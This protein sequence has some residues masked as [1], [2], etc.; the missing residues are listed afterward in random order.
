M[1]GEIATG[2]NLQMG[3][4]AN[5]L[6]MYSFWGEQ[7]KPQENEPIFN[8]SRAPV[9]RSRVLG[10]GVA[11]P[12]VHGGFVVPVLHRPVL[13]GYARGPRWFR[14][15]SFPL[16][17]PPRQLVH[18]AVDAPNTDAYRMGDTMRTHRGSQVQ[19]PQNQTVHN[20]ECNMVKCAPCSSVI[21]KGRLLEIGFPAAP[22]FSSVIAN[23]PDK[24]PV[25]N[26]RTRAKKV[27]PYSGMH[28]RFN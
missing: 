9:N 16:S 24:S 5:G 4:S 15:V 7:K 2:F 27:D 3:Q 12:G 11:I 14:I 26:F 17:F 6:P 22:L 18:G 10:H 23:N 13:G 21:R 25:V 8:T 1:D 19:P 20:Y 28:S